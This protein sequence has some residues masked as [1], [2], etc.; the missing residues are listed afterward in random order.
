MCADP[1]KLGGHDNKKLN[2]IKALETNFLYNF[3]FVNFKT[4]ILK[5]RPA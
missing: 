1:N 2:F 3:F 5:S 4:L